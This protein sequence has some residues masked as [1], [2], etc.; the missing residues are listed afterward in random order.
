[1]RLLNWLGDTFRCLEPQ[2]EDFLRIFSFWRKKIANRKRFLFALHVIQKWTYVSKYKIVGNEAPERAL[3]LTLDNVLNTK[4]YHCKVQ[5]LN[6]SDCSALDLK[7]QIF[8]TG[9]P[10]YRT[11][12]RYFDTICNLISPLSLKNF[13]CQSESEKTKIWC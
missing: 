2:S 6:F 9:V 1:M 3:L 7:F 10:H 12:C 11:F 5:F 13:P 4:H 8:L